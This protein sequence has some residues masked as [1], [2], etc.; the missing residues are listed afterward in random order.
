MVASWASWLRG[1]IIVSA[2]LLGFRCR[3]DGLSKPCERVIELVRLTPVITI[4]PEQDGGLP[5]PRVPC[6]IIG[7]DGR[8]VLAGKARVISETGEDRTAAYL[9]GAGRALEAARRCGATRAFLKDGS[10]SCGCRRLVRDGQEV[11]GMGVCA[12]LLEKE[13]LEIIAF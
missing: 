6:E 4:C 5:T 2:C 8:D 11:S 9:A 10:P 7:G 12:A 1:M 13:G 3:Y